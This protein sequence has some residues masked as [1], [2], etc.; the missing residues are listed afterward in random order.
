MRTTPFPDVVHET[1][2]VGVYPG[3]TPAEG[4]ESVGGDVVTLSPHTKATH[5]V[6]DLG[7]DLTDALAAPTGESSVISKRFTL[8]LWFQLVLISSSLPAGVLFHY[9][10]I[11]GRYTLT[12][13]EA[14]QACRDIGAEIA[15]P[16]QLQAAFESGFHQCDAGWLSDQ[17]VRCHSVT[18]ETVCR[19][20]TGHVAL[21]S[22]LLLRYPIVSPRENCAGNLP[23]LPGVRSY[24]PRPADEQYDVF[25]YIQ[26]LQGG[27]AVQKHH[28]SQQ[29]PKWK[30]LPTASARSGLLRQRLRQ[31]LLRR[32][33]AALSQTQRHPGHHCADLRRLEPRP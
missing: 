15:S 29:C 19:V 30:L 9:R 28:Y 26:R 13:A 1:P 33:C 21:T 18:L 27:L 31:L 16:A 10:P 7:L 32:G 3:P 20:K 17:T 5:V 25:C 23:R 4:E 22:A 2:A 11:T 6:G 8:L 24:G 12:F 14:Q